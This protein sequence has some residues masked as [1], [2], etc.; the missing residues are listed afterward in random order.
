MSL[1]QKLYLLIA[2]S[3]L[4][5][6]IPFGLLV[7]LFKGIDPRKA[8]SGNI[9]ATNVG[10]LLGGKYFALVF[11]LDMLKSL[12]PMLLAGFILRHSTLLAQD[13]FLWLCIGFAAFLGHLFPIFIGFRGGKGVSTSA[14]ILLGLWPYYTL[15]GMTAIAV[16]ISVFFA[17]RYIS[18]ASLT[19]SVLFPVIYLAFAVI[20]DWEPFGRQFPLLVFSVLIGGLVVFKHR[21]NIAR[22]RA[23]TENKFR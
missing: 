15:P 18:A 23:G 10:R 13:Y 14:G 6:S 19:A 21:G 11:C 3:Y 4:L 20:G 22:L 2:S 8:G 17:T 9:G 12:V 1:H 7:G 5:G 16:F